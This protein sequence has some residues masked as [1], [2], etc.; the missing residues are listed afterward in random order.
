LFEDDLAFVRNGLTAL[1]PT[2]DLQADFDTER[3]LVTI[4]VNDE[5]RRTFR[6]LPAEALPE[7]GRLNFTTNRDR[8]KK[9]IKDSRAEESRWPNVHLLWNLHPV[10]EWLN[11]KLMVAFGRRQAPVLRLASV[12]G[13]SESLFLF[14]GEIPNR[15]GQPVIHEWFAVQ[16]DGQRL[17]GML[18]LEQF[19]A[20]TQ[21]AV[22]LFPNTG[23]FDIPVAVTGLLPEAVAEAR[24]YM[25][26][27]REDF[28]Q[29]L[30]LRLKEQ[31][32][33]LSE[34]QGRQLSFLECEYPEDQT[35]VGSRRNKKLE[36]KRHID[37]VF[38]DYRRFMEDTLTTKDNPFLRV[39]A[40]FLG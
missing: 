12:L 17:A 29:D 15:K 34:L 3:Q 7:D 11:F 5:L 13:S 38:A 21:L 33:S 28:E 39:A 25:S 19:L 35:L 2:I 9:A 24:S 14:E 20:Q 40:V 4:T 26:S 10:M 32:E 18:S 6:A 27:R 22:R 36:R 30:S 8:V 23:G 16:F 1:R 31:I 37:A